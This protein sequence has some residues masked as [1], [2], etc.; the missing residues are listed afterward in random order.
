MN[1]RNFI[2]GISTLPFIYGLPKL[3]DLAGNNHMGVVIHSYHRRF[4]TQKAAEGF[5]IFS[6]TR[7][8]IRHCHQLGAGGVQVTLRDW[9]NDFAGK[10]RQL[11]EELGMYL[12]GSIGL[13]KDEND[14]D[15]FS[16]Q[17]ELA[18][19]AGAS[20]IRTVC[21]SGRRYETFQSLEAFKTFKKKAIKSLEL[22]IPIIQK[23]RVKLGVENHKDWRVEELIPI[24]QHLSS[25]WIGVTLDFGNSIS[26]MEDPMET[27]AGLAPFVFSTHVKD[28]GLREYKDGFLLSE[29]PLGEGICDLEKMMAICRAWNPEIN[30][31]LEMITRDPLKVPCLSDKYWATFDQVNG[32]KL[33]DTL[34]LV[35]N[36][37]YL[38]DLPTVSHLDWKAQ[39]AVEEQ[40]VSASLE[41]SRNELGL[42]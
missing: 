25:E 14:V 5:Q 8:L 34:Q 9:S 1:R 11:R 33:A 28:M 37:Q 19:E 6:D 36:H 7:D 12:E 13:P 39:V 2:Y 21:L 40:N 29:V 10:V 31:N 32:K 35:R 22:A 23:H 15:R 26:L 42:K 20:I 38:G 17:I 3:R 30:F 24:L 27:V 16:H 4:N 41:Y 18:K